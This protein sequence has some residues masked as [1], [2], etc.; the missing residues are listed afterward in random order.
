MFITSCL[1]LPKARRR[2]HTFCNWSYRWLCAAM[3]VLETE[4]G[5]LEEQ[6]VPSAPEPSFYPYLFL[7]TLYG[8]STSTSLFPFLLT[9]PMSP[10]KIYGLFFI[11]VIDV[12]MYMCMCTC[13]CTC[14]CNLLSTFSLLICT[15][16]Q[17]WTLHMQTHSWRKLISLL[18]AAI[19]QLFI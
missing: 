8:I 19:D 6:P 10:F 12:Y 9:P 11:I 5:S 1:V 15:P 4:P 7:R 18:S 3:W 2:Y 17:D 13:M 14:I 16:V